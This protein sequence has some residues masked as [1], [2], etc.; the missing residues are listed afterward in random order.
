M[1]SHA[2]YPGLLCYLNVSHREVLLQLSHGGVH[3]FASFILWYVVFS[4]TQI[5]W[6]VLEY[7]TALSSL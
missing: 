7:D 2:W 4:G 5:V 3:D 6:I 1:H